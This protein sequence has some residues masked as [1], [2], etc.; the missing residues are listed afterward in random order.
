MTDAQLCEAFDG[1]ILYDCHHIRTRVSRSDAGRKLRLNARGTLPVIVTHLENHRR[2]DE[3]GPPEDLRLG[4]GLLLNWIA[5]DL[6]AIDSAPEFRTDTL[7]WI[8]WAK[9]IAA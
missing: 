1:D 6:G 2:L 3:P 4:W 7:G 5:V 9:K 8:A